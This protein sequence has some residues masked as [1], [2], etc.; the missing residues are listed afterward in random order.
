MLSRERHKL[1]NITAYDGNQI[2]VV[3]VIK[4]NCYPM[5]Q[6]PREDYRVGLT[7]CFPVDIVL[8]AKKIKGCAALES[9]SKS[10]TVAPAVAVFY[11]NWNK[12][13]MLKL[14]RS[15]CPSQRYF[16]SM[17]ERQRQRESALIWRQ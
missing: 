13:I 9:P 6:Q 4:R 3:S 10:V 14:Q 2:A 5:C 8:N 15:K 1:C 12:T 17:R 16:G 11:Q 7:L